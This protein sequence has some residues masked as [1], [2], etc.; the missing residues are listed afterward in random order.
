MKMVMVIAP[1][2]EHEAVRALIGRHDVHAYTELSEVVGAGAT[3]RHFGTR[4]WPGKSIL[5]FTVV[6]DAKRGELLSA[7]KEFAKTLMPA[8][9]MRVFVLPVEEML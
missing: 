2:S 6:P 4:V 1:E 7:L 3:G 9:G 8:E 5:I